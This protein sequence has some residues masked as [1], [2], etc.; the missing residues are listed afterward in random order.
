MMMCPENYV[1][2]YEDA[3]FE[4]LIAARDGLIEEIR[5]LEKLVFDRNKNDDTWNILPSPD[6]QYQVNLDYLSELCKLIRNKYNS[7]IVWG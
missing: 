2:E 4:E 6:V 3:S 5:S 1:S 7:E